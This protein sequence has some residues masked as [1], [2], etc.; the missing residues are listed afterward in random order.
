MEFAHPGTAWHLMPSV[1][2]WD[3]EGL[4]GINGNFDMYYHFLPG[5][6]VTPYA[7]TGLGVN[8]FDP[9]GP[10]NGSTRLGLN[11]FG[12]LRLPAGGTRLFLE[13]RYTASELSQ[14]SV[15]GGIT[16]LGGR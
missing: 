1:M 12:G 7:G 13:G 8:H 6:Q 14:I 10:D 9:E 3:A 2:V 16:F 11:L 15:L 4:T 5:S